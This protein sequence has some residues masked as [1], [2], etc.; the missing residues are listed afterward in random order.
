MRVAASSSSRMDKYEVGALV[1]KGSFGSVLLVT[2]RS[3]GAQFVLKRLPLGG[4][5]LGSGGLGG[6]LGGG[7]GGGMGGG[8]GAGSDLMDA[9]TN[10]IQLLSELEHPGIVTYVESFVDRQRMD[11]CIVM[12]YCDGG[13]LSHM[14]QRQRDNKA[15]G[16]K[17]GSKLRESDIRST[18]VQMALAL[19]FMHEKN[20]LHRDLKTG[21]VFLKNGMVQ[22][23][24]FGISKVL[25]GTADLASTCIGTPYVSRAHLRARERS[26]R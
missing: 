23:G 16:A 14:I 12:R 3:D 25:N 19:H 17:S 2:R 7:G 13:D 26:R 1:G 20:I 9:Y 21:N 10:E 8:G 15:G 5:G 4:A 22:L 18:F 6:G 11:L 24:D